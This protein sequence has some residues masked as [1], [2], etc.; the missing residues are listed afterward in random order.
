MMRASLAVIAA[1]VV[2]G[3][4]GARAE[5]ADG[6]SMVELADQGFLECSRPDVRR[7]TCRAIGSY[8]RIREGVYASTTLMAVGNG[9][10]LEI[11]TP[12]W[13]VDGAFCGSIREQDVMTAIVRLRGREVAAHIAAPALQ[14]ALRQL[15]PV[16]EQEACVRFEPSGEAYIAKTSIGG[17]YRAEH[18]TAVKMVS[19]SDGYRVAD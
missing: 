12:V 3:S 11:Y 19:P 6:A 1:A 13:L 10:T 14:H 2:L 16:I 7:K 4:S 5:E 17:E 9:A 15:G 18:D 8:E